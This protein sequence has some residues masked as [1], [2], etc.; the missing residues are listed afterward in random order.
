MTRTVFKGGSLFDGSGAPPAP[1]DFAVVD[2]R[3]VDVGS[4]LDGDTVFDVTG[5]T[6]LPGLF[7]CHTHVVF[8]HVDIWRSVQTPFSY[9]FFEAAQ[10]LERTLRIGITTVPDAGGADLGIQQ[11]VA[12]GLTPGPRLQI[13]L[14]MLSQ[15]GGHGDD[16]CDGQS[17]SRRSA[18]RS[19]RL[20]RATRAASRT[21]RWRVPSGTSPGRVRVT[22]RTFFV[23]PCGAPSG[24]FM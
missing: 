5:R 22:H 10:N 3:I 2:G 20:S 7:D 6:I 21:S 23:A 9:R 4:A 17:R 13:S 15:T 16:W 14:R 18:S 19:A 11:A 8:S 24:S 1:A 12:D